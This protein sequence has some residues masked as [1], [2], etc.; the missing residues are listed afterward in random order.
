MIKA[1]LVAGFLIMVYNLISGLQLRRS[2][3]GGIIGTR[4]NQ[5]LVFI[6]LFAA[7]YA[8]I[9]VLIWPQAVGTPLVLVL[10]SL[11]LTFGAVF[12][13]LALRLVSAI[14]DA[15]SV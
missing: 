6:G 7:G 9:G 3:T 5:L 12:V 11:I 2:V 1:L 10:L 8:A 15:V 4:L 14:A 13:L